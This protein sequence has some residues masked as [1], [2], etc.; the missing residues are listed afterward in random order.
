M[1]TGLNTRLN[2]R[3]HGPL[4]ALLATA[5]LL[6]ACASGPSV[7]RSPVAPVDSATI[8]D[9]RYGTVRDIEVIP[10]SERRNAA[11]AVLGG[12]IGAIVG[13]QVGSGSGRTA[14]TGVGAVAG[15]VIGNQVQKRNTDDVYRV[16]VRFDNGDRRSFDVREVGDLRIGE[17]VRYDGELH[18]TYG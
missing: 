16:T 15:A 12:V 18:R 8:N 17:R 5:T 6:G 9:V 1:N 10:A 3:L 13:N 14:A 11:G 2:T 4:A 7:Q